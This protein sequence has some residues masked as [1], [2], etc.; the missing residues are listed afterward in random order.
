LKHHGTTMLLQ[1]QV[2]K[3]IRKTTKSR[4][5]TISVF[6]DYS[7]A[8][9]TKYAFL[10]FL[11]IVFKIST[12]TNSKTPSKLLWFFLSSLLWLILGPILFSICVGD[13]STIVKNSQCLQYVDDSN[14]YQHCKPVEIDTYCENTP[15]LK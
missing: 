15:L 7:K 12:V 10:Q 13:M 3:R 14:I 1:T 6:A 4:E 9:D 8:F 5:I 11:K 2:K